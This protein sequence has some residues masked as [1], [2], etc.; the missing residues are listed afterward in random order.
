MTWASACPARASA[1]GGRDGRPS[2]LGGEG[3][4]AA[5]AVRAGEPTEDQ[6]A[7]AS[8]R[9]MQSE[10]SAPAQVWRLPPCPS[11]GSQ[12]RPEWLAAHAFCQVGQGCMV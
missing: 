11:T 10:Y 9:T 8:V 6:R 5:V 7:G 12:S 3:S 2:R 4:A 1:R